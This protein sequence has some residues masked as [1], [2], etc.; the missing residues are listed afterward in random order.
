MRAASRDLAWNMAKSSVFQPFS[1]I[2]NIQ[3]CY[4]TPIYVV[5]CSS[6]LFR[7]VDARRYTRYGIAT[8]GSTIN[9][10]VARVSCIEVYMYV[11]MHTSI[12]MIL[13]TVYIEKNS[14]S[15]IYMSVL[16]GY[17]RAF[18]TNVLIGLYAELRVIPPLHTPT[19]FHT[20]TCITAWL[21]G[22]AR[23]NAQS[24]DSRIIIRTFAPG[25]LLQ[26]I[27]VVGRTLCSMLRDSLG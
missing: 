22:N 10:C 8:L 4:K 23:N 15:Y 1:G 11:R 17:S 2:Y 20:C 12:I 3:S 13:Y 24:C 27:G 21:C 26:G 16:C 9:C 6:V 19:P 18:H 25:Y 5:Q 14:F 7:A